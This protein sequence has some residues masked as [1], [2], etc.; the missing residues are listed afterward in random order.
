MDELDKIFTSEIPDIEKL[1]QSFAWITHLE[2]ENTRHEIE[3][4]KALNDPDELVKEQVKLST[5]EHAR[6][7]FL[8]CHLRITG[9]LAWD[10]PLH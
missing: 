2:M 10:E 1:T 3:L 8:F 4:L 7:I 9:K 5:L 6:K